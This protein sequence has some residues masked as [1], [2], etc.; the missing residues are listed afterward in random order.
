MLMENQLNPH[1]S[2][3]SSDDALCSLILAK[4]RN[5]NFT[6]QIRRT[7]ITA[8]LE[9]DREVL[10]SL[11][12]NIQ[13]SSLEWAR[14][15]LRRSKAHGVSVISIAHRSY[16]QRL[17]HIPDPPLVLFLRG[18]L[19]PAV[20]ARSDN[21]IVL[22][23]VGSRRSTHYGNRMA[24]R[25][26]REVLECGGTVISGL[27]YGI[28]AQAHEGALEGYFNVK[29]QN[30]NSSELSSDK[31][32]SDML[33]SGVAVLGTGVLSVY[34][35]VHQGLAERLVENNGVVMSE[36]GLSKTPHGYTFPERN[37]IIS[38]LSDAVIIVEAAAK[39]GA[40]ITARC[41]LEQGREVF[42]VPGPVDHPNSEGVFK[43]I[44]DGASLIRGIDDVFQ[45][46]PR[47][48]SRRKPQSKAQGNSPHFQNSNSLDSQ[49]LESQG[50][51]FKL[52]GLDSAAEDAL[53][54]IKSYLEKHAIVHFDEL[55]HISK[56][57]VNELSSV[58]T[59]LE[60]AECILQHPGQFYALSDRVQV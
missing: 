34:P 57:A 52:E 8:I 35:S 46:L 37:R 42:V 49:R 41:A 12:S 13:D 3:D 40:L 21:R 26:A 58:L 25:L 28:D 2:L 6:A 44:K 24:R 15:E 11:F 56:L 31:L 9:Q 38:G 51:E 47:F 39:S 19:S 18:V 14:S 23:I 10:R 59:R 16:P 32:S 50:R 33:S 27:A 60:L 20:F 17:L 5:E 43:L 4:Q 48:Q 55:H 1:E 45:A 22:A 36:Y 29:N 53:R 7:V 30:P 54:V